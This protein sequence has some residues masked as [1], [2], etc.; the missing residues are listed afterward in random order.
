M[1][2]KT[3]FTTMKEPCAAQE[4]NLF[5]KCPFTGPLKAS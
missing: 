5:R 1:E 2:R 3:I 4:K